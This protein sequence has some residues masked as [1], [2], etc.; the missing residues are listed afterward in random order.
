MSLEQILNVPA[1]SRE[2]AL[3]GRFPALEKVLA[4]GLPAIVYPAANLGRHAALKLRERGVN[5]VGLGD[6]KPTLWG[7]KVGEIPVLSPGQIAAEHAETPILIATSRF[8]SEIAE[9]LRGKG[10]RTVIPMPYLNYRLPDVFISPAY[11]GSVTMVADPEQREDINR[12]YE[13]LAD[14]PSRR[15]FATKL[16]YYLTLEKALLDRCRT[17][18]PIYFDPEVIHLTPQEVFVDGGAFT[19]DTLA[20]FLK[21]SQGRF[22]AYFGFEPDS[23]NFAQLEKAASVDPARIHAVRAGVAH[24]TGTLRFTNT[25]REDSRVAADDD[26]NAVVVP[27]ESLDEYFED[28]ETP[29]FIK[30]DIEG[31]EEEALRGAARLI[32]NAH[33]ILAVSVYH[34]PQ[35]LWELPLLIHTLNPGY[36]F[37]MRHYTREIDDTVCYAVPP[38]RVR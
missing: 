24:K 27:V 14:E 23:A 17:L 18:E 5:I 31:V 20:P 15:V 37:F 32:K 7:S 2:A 16:E 13:L 36:R 19:G 30:L 22:R 34:K 10:C 26:P 4:G 33:P 28:R 1:S 11:K 25:S 21:A 29:T 3:A 8:D 12:A 38:E 9:S 6:S 35:D